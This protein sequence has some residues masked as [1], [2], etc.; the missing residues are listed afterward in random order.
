MQ[1][2]EICQREKLVF[3]G[4]LLLIIFSLLHCFAFVFLSRIIAGTHFVSCREKFVP[5]FPCRNSLVKKSGRE[6][7]EPFINS[8]SKSKADKIAC[9]QANICL[10]TKFWTSFCKTSFADLQSIRIRN[11]LRKRSSWNFEMHKTIAKISY[12]IIQYFCCRPFQGPEWKRTNCSFWDSIFCLRIYPY[13]ISDASVS[14]IMNA[15]GLGIPRHGNSL[16]C[17][18]TCWITL[19]CLFVHGL[20][21][22]L[23]RWYRGAHIWRSFEKKLDT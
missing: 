17:T 22:F 23:S 10:E 19:V 9:H 4:H 3:Y 18:L 14:T 20:G 15:C 21:F 1:W 6:L 11:F 8:I 5:L 7:S 12:F 16:T 13:P 2:R